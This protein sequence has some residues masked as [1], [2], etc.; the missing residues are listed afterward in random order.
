MTPLRKLESLQAELAGL[1]SLLRSTPE[2][3]IATPMLRGRIASVEKSVITLQERPPLA[4][5]AEIFF[6]DGPAMDSEGLE[7]TFTSG[8]LESYQNMV[9]N[10]YSAKNYG[11]LRRS[12][13]R[14]GEKD[15]QLYLT[16]LPRASFGL[17]LSQPH[18]GDFVIAANL[19]AALLDISR[20]VE[21]SVESDPAFEDAIATVNPRV[22]H[23]LTRFI[24]TLH[25]GGGEC[26][27]VTG[28]HETRL[29]A[30]QITQ[31]YER[32]VAA[33]TEEDSISLTG[34]FGGVLTFSWEFDFQPEQG[35]L[36]HGSLGQD[37]GE[38]TATG[39]NLHHTHQRVKAK[40]NIATVSTRTGKKKPSYELLDIQPIDP[41]LTEPPPAPKPKT[42]S[43]LPE[44][45]Y[46]RK[47]VL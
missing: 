10:H 5:G 38:E 3:D 19:T 24:T 7:A 1:R 9:T 13:R 6:K 11:A 43:A 34:I 14:R 35:E 20:L 46:P 37:V 45:P 21:A 28:F 8:V 12:G 18:V 47:L 2:H 36:I 33:R 4:P 44:P 29:T 39:W 42:P 40:L 26:R 23:P 41:R 22:I 30:N 31:A 15:A 27:L 25:N 17:Q 16:G 32:V